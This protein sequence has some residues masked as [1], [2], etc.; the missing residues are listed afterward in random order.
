MIRCFFALSALVLASG[1]AS[2]TPA[3]CRSA[4]WQAVGYQDGLKGNPDRL[5]N[6]RQACARAGVAPETGADESYDEGWN[7]GLASYCA[8][9]N[10]F[11]QGRRGKQY[12]GVCGEDLE[13][14]FLEAY[15]DGLLVGSVEQRHR[16]FSLYYS[17]YTSPPPPWGAGWGVRR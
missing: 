10:A 1:C 15:G 16:A 2:M 6:R 11:V 17:G 12:H 14:A 5:E 4:N 13:A 7:D 9:A 8:P 3:D